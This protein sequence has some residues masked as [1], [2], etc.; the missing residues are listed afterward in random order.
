MEELI[1]REAFDSW[2]NKVQSSEGLRDM[3]HGLF[4]QGA[5]VHIAFE[6]TNTEDAAAF[7][8]WMSRKQGWASE[9][10][11]VPGLLQ[12]DLIFDVEGY[13]RRQLAEQLEAY[14]NELRYSP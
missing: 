10:E 13:Q 5:T 2:K 4:P 3:G 9:Q 7:F 12:R 14:A 11:A 8:L 6:V 1:D